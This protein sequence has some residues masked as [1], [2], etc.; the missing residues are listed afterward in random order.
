MGPYLPT[1]RTAKTLIG[2]G[3]CPGRSE[4]RWAHSHFVDFVMRRLIICLTV[5]HTSKRGRN[6]RSVEET[7]FRED[8]STVWWTNLETLKLSAKKQK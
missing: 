7:L 6:W 3:G 5:T 8:I 1:E 2:L 4:F